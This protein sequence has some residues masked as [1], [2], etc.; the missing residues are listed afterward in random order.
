MA[1]ADRNV[2]GSRIVAVII[3][4]IIVAGLGYAF[5]T[6]LAM[7]YIK[8]AKE[9][10]NAFDVKDPPPPPEE[11]PPPPPD[12]PVPPPPT[13]V[14]SPPSIV[15]P[16]VTPPSNFNPADRPNER[17]VNPDPISTPVPTPT[18]PAGP[19]PVPPKPPTPRG[20]PQGWVTDDDY[21]AAAIR[22]EKQGVTGVR[23]SVDASGRVT[24]CTVT[25]SSG[26]S[27]LDSTACNLL[28]RR[29]KFN[30]ATDSAGNKV[31]GSWSSRF[32]WTLPR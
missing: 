1:Y 32:R 26:S 28:R 17:P 18:P 5:V 22:E 2:S 6:G 31:P 24:D 14:Y 19:P 11:V 15:P 27:A 29:A 10:L 12:K 7:S 3:V 20:Q 25:S 21:P 13:Q 16:P 9:D 8:K 30:P 23:L 4:A